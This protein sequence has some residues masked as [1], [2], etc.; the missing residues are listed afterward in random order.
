MTRCITAACVVAGFMSLGSPPSAAQG[1]T[2]TGDRAIADTVTQLLSGIASATSSLDLDRLRDYYERSEAVTYVAQGRVV[3]SYGAFSGILNAQLGGLR[4]ADL[5]WGDT[6]VDVLGQD[7]A[8]A[9]ATYE[10]TAIF[11]DGDS[12]RS[13][14]TYTCIFVRGDAGW[15]VR[16]SAHSFPPPSP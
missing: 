12:A 15:R 16:H 1:P 14:G 4:A 3:R 10:L 13:S 5:R 6:Y 9:T 2:I 8:V 7:V 11:P